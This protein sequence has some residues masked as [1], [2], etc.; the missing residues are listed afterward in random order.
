VVLRE[1]ATLSEDGVRAWAAETLAAFK[2]PAHVEF[3]DSLPYTQNG[4]VKKHELETH[5]S[6]RKA[7]R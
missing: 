3:R 6:E 7:R 4:K 5:E 2:V 1:G